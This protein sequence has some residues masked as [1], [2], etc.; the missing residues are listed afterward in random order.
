[1][2]ASSSIPV[3]LQGETGSGKE[4]I[5]RLIHS[6][7]RRR[8]GALVCL[9]CGAIPATLVEST[10]FGHEKGAYTGALQQQ[11]GVFEAADGGT[12]LLAEVGELPLAAQ[13]ALLRALETKRVTR[14]G[15]TREIEVDVRVI[16]ATHRDLEAMCEE[17]TF[18]SDLYYRLN[19]MVL[20]VPALAARRDD[21]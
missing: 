18:R 10:L 8:E 14:V 12:L 16:A 19:T 21:I 9:N 7:G 6:S 20:A 5:A 4:L 11:K 2:L 3:L 15:G 13:A 17:G 1:R